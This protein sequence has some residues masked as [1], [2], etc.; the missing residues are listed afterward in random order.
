M[1]DPIR[2]D[3][4]LAGDEAF[5]ALALS[6]AVAA[7]ERGEVPV[8]AVVIGADG[9]V[10]G[11]SANRTIELADPSGH[12]E[13]LAL[14]EAGQA[15]GNYRLTGCTVYVTLEPCVMCAGA[16]VHARICRLVYGAID[17]KGGGVD[18]LYRVG[19]DGLLN[20]R[21]LVTGGVLADSASEMLKGF[22]RERRRA[23]G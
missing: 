22:F 16:M 20:H 8:G 23:A 1:S 18:S 19:V 3:P 10:L 9:R 12:A 2:T 5:M 14:R 17:P 21:F 15:L 7:S 6:E 13:I 4:A 11:R